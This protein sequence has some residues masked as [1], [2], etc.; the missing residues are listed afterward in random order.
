MSRRLQANKEKRVEKAFEF[1]EM[2]SPFEAE[3]ETE[4]ANVKCS[5]LLHVPIAEEID[6]ILSCRDFVLDWVYLRGEKGFVVPEKEASEHAL[7]KELCFDPLIFNG[8]SDREHY[9]R[10]L[11]ERTPF[12]AARVFDAHYSRKLYLCMAPFNR[13]VF[14]RLEESDF[15]VTFDYDCENALGGERKDSRSHSARVV[16]DDLYHLACMESRCYWLVRVS[17]EIQNYYKE[18]GGKENCEMQLRKCEDGSYVIKLFHY[19]YTKGFEV[20][21]ETADRKEFV[22]P[23]LICEELGVENVNE[24]YVNLAYYDDKH[25]VWWSKVD[26]ILNAVKNTLGTV[27]EPAKIVVSEVSEVSA[28]FMSDAFSIERLGVPII[29]AIIGVGMVLLSHTPAVR[30]DVGAASEAGRDAI[31]RIEMFANL[32]TFCG[33]GVTLL[34]AWLAVRAVFGF[35]IGDD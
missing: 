34:G 23:A 11:D 27:E 21:P 16:V 8:T 6:K 30:V 22:L 29:I 9:K 17:A 2:E 1:P 18:H 14:Q 32:L 4:S 19:D 20:M 15:N 12:E 5:D 7:V 24:N 33:G 25:T 28:G 26:E 3:A 35:S 31:N 10:F 13:S